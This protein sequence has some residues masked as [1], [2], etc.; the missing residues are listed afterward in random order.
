VAWSA[1]ADAVAYIDRGVLWTVRPDGRDRRQIPIPGVAA[2]PVWAP[3]GDRLVVAVRQTGADGGRS[4]VWLTS[5]DG[6]LNRPIRWETHGR[7]ITALG[8]FPDTLHL[9]VGLAAPDG[10]ATVEWWQ[11][12]ISY[13]DFRRLPG[14]PQPA[15][16]SAPSP[17]G[18]WVAFVSADGGGERAYVVRLDGGGLHAIS[19]VARRIDGLAWSPHGDKVAYGLLLDETR[20]EIYISSTTGAAPVFVTS[21]HLEFPDPAAG[22]SLAWAPDEVHL[23]YGTDTGALG[24]PVWIATFESR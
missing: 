11:V 19:P 23:A 9:F 16:E 12:R 20:A 5:V 4:S 15:L 10:D 24:G 6:T 3:G 18:D 8:W 13:P 21:Y 2:A 22:L 14:P 7:H 1:A 17:R